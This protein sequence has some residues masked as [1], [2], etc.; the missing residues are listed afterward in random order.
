[1]LV[2]PLTVTPALF[3]LVGEHAGLEG[4]LLDMVLVAIAGYVLLPLAF[5]V[6]L[7]KTGRI[8]TIEARDRQRRSSALWIGAGLLALAGIAT[9]WMAGAEYGP[10]PAVAALLV[11]NALIAAAVNER[12]KISLHVASVAGLFAILA[13]LEVL[14]G[15]PMPGGSWVLGI[16]LLLIPALMWARMA[17]GAHSRTEVIA[18]W[19]FG[20]FMPA[21]ELWVLD[22][23]RPLY[24]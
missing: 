22:A 8:A 15:R 2:N 20:L 18:G 21:L 7:Q 16:A 1:M 4:S 13:V 9:S 23:F 11:L 19:L 5:L 6:W 3:A 10:V 17:D 14:S 12:F 24:G